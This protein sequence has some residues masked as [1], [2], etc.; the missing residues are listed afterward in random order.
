MPKPRPPYPSV[1]GL[2]GKPT[3]INNVETLSNVSNII[4]KGGSWYSSMGT[5]KK[6]GNKSI[7][8]KRQDRK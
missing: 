7:C 5:E 6:Q 1:S 2:W 4:A 8:L 3:I